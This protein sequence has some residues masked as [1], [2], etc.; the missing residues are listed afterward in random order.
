L[1]RRLYFDLIGLPPAPL[2]IDA[3]LSDSN[4]QAYQR[5]V[6]RLLAS[7]HYGERWARHWMDVVHYG[8]THGY[9]KDKPRP[10]AWPYRDYVIR[11]FNS[12]KSYWRFV[13][14]QIAGDVLWP[15]ESDAIV[16]TGFIAA[17]PWDFIGHAEVPESK[18]DG[19]VARNLDRDDMVSSTMNTFASM[20]VQC[21]RCHDHKFDPVTQE[22]Y[23]SLQ[24]VFAALDRADRPYD[25]D[26]AV[27]RQRAKLE[28]KRRRLDQ[29]NQTLQA[30]VSE[31]GGEELAAIDKRTAELTGEKS[32][33][34]QQ[35]LATLKQQRQQLLDR[36]LDE[37]TKSRLAA[38]TTSLDS[39]SNQLAALPAASVVYAG[40]VHHGSGTFLG[41]GHDGG[42]PREIYVLA[43]G[44]V[45]QPGR[46]VRPGAVAIMGGADW[47]FDL[48]EDHRE[49]D[50]RV[51]LA[52]WITRVDNPLTWRS[53]VNRVW[54]YHFGRGLV[55][56]PN[57]FGR[58]GAPP[59]HPELLD[60]LAVRF[61]D[62]GQSLKDL[63]RL[64]V[65]SNVY[66]QSSAAD[67]G[68]ARVDADNRYLWRMNR[69]A[70]DAESIRDSV[71]TVSGKLD[72]QMYGPAFM[73]FVVEKPE[74][75]PHYEY[76]KYDPDDT[77]THRRSVYRFLV[78]SQQQP[79]MQ[80][81]DCAD[82]SQSVARRDTTLTAT[83]A[84]ALLNN[85]F[86]V[87][88]SEHFAQRVTADCPQ[89]ASAIEAAFRLAAGRAPNADERGVLVTY[90]DRFGIENACRVI[91][92]LNES[93]FID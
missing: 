77:T 3:F 57:D 60:W 42:R 35:Q 43:R 59:T 14:E 32:D 33:D 84:L 49:G 66:R 56:T 53:I 10:N 79:F 81:L 30:R 48:P 63:H 29:R 61:R 1:I 34:V 62:G 6:D 73:D 41:T 5:L 28:A 72:R 55:E 50:R 71:L 70:L 37:A 92:N 68:K 93:V 7:P 40:T 20:T 51:A 47:H 9:D 4:P 13:R 8:D 46:L 54:H 75:S 76:H 22:Q 44:E 27:A 23:Y 67:G 78:R 90:A 82:P 12:D 52:N 16:A 2:E 15:F 38:V 85:R 31:L 39:V 86:M 69:R 91:L 45:T 36:I 65:T 17:G 89:T 25:E 26:P 87:R 11:S 83:Q 21:A 88:M 64:F 58:M 74:H 19:K 24:A 80:T 18:I